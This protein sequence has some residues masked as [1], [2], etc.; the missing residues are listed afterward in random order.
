MQCSGQEA[1]ICLV[2]E[3]PPSGAVQV[4]TGPGVSSVISG[5]ILAE[6]VVYVVTLH[7][8]H[9]IVLATCCSVAKLHDTAFYVLIA[10]ES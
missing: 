8:V 10:S 4:C 2:N 1:I 6:E 7:A 9:E 3:Q 5:T